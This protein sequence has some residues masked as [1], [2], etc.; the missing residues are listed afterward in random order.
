MYS[1]SGYLVTESLEMATDLKVWNR[2]KKWE[3]KN[4]SRWLGKW[5]QLAPY[6]YYIACS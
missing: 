4:A 1:T 5:K 2:Q 3:A 6:P